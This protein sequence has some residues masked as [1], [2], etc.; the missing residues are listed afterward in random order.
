MSDV[1]LLHYCAT[2]NSFQSALPVQLLARVCAVCF[3][4]Y[5]RPLF[6]WKENSSAKSAF[7]QCMFFIGSESL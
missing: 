3:L 2:F 6:S 4:V 5:Q 1:Y 7:N